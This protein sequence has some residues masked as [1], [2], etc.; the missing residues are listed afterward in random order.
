MPDSTFQAKD[1]GKTVSIPV[2]Q[3]FRLELEENPTTGYRWSVPEFDQKCLVLESNEYTPAGGAGIGGGG[4]RQFGFAVKSPCRTKIHLMNK[5]P[6]EKDAAPEA[7]FEI[8]VIG[9]Q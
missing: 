3:R 2:G 7:T 8:T 1:N 9:L 5:R 4:V 6:W